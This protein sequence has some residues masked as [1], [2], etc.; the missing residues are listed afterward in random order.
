MFEVSQGVLMSSAIV[1]FSMRLEAMR[2]SR[3]EAV[4]LSRLGAETTTYRLFKKHVRNITTG[5]INDV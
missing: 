3:G 4:K 5:T 2:S 1:G